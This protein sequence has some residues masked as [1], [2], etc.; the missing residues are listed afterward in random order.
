MHILI[1]AIH[2]TLCHYN[3]ECKSNILHDSKNNSNQYTYI[4][5]LT[6]HSH[7]YI[8]IVKIIVLNIPIYIHT[9]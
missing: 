4:F 6:D 7:T 1:I 2:N 8:M 3:N 9:Y 5:I